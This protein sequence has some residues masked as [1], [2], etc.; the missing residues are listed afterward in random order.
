MQ[1][2]K[3]QVWQPLLFSLV[4]IGGMIIGYKIKGNMPAI[5]IFSTE[6]RRPVQEVLNLIE[7]KYVDKENSDS[8]GD[9]A[10]EAILSKLDPHSVFLPAAQLQ[11]AKE[12]LQGGFSGIGVE[13]NIFS[14][15]INVLNV[16]KDG[17]S[18]K[19]GIQP[20]DKLLKVGD[21]IVAGNKINTAKIQSLLRGKGGTKAE[22]T[23]LRGNEQKH[24]SIIRG[25]IHLYSLDAA[26]MVTDSVGYIR[27]NKFAETTYKEFMDATLKLQKLGMKSMILDL[28]DNG[29]G[30]LTQATNI[31]DE[32]LSE[33][34]LITYIEGAHAPKKEYRCE[35]EGI[36]EKGKVVVLANEGSASASEI[37][38]GALQ[39]WDRAEII[40]RRT[41]G[42]GLVQDQYELSDGSGLRLT[43]ARY[44]T[45]L[46]RSIQKSYSSG[47]KVYNED[48]INRM[49]DGE[50][51]YFDSIKH[52]NGKAYK[53]KTGKI[54]YSGGGI[55][56][57]IFVAVDTSGLNAETRKIYTKGTINKFVY[58]NYLANKNKFTAYTSAIQ[59][60]KS[61]SVDEAAWTSFKVFAAKD[62]IN[63]DKLGSKER[64]AI[65]KQ[66]KILT[67]RQVWGN[68]GLYEVSN[69]E[70]AMVKKA[71]EALRK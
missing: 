25:M 30:I 53:T 3:L 56:P 7:N 35:K 34:K 48:M 13:Y 18:D 15:T 17:P 51:L 10:I 57:D 32:F 12:D 42:K 61:Y 2:K 44:Y 24:F 64:A 45:P 27:L 65:S 37:L 5:G 22:I 23:I 14:D 67:A 63:T 40:G 4:M 21:S 38:I 36:F 11:S 31:A 68:Q 66:I 8:L 9:A 19:A 71:L 20:G 54:V 28:R 70:D 49:H 29:G 16:I 55:T 41:F 47:T 52:T 69:A 43:V 33:N 59:F 60:Q 39:D 6:K 50:L 46:G 26:Y 1:N 62:S 58:R